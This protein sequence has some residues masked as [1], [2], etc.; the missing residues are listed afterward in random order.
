MDCLSCCRHTEK[1]HL[2]S[3][4][5]I[6]ALAKLLQIQSFPGNNIRHFIHFVPTTVFFVVFVRGAFT[7]QCIAFMILEDIQSYFPDFSSK[8]GIFNIMSSTSTHFCSRIG[9]VVNHGW[10]MIHVLQNRWRT[11]SLITRNSQGGCFFTGLALYSAFFC[12]VPLRQ[13]RMTFQQLKWSFVAKQTS[14]KLT[15][16]DQKTKYFC[17]VQAVPPPEGRGGWVKG[18]RQLINADAFIW[19]LCYWCQHG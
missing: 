19:Q 9:G 1:A 11:Q 14:N 16:R 10:V 6:L 8:S 2:P 18:Q 15:G 4:L 13:N 5:V 17:Q 7:A 3:S 12:L